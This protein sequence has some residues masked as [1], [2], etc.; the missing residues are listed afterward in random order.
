M[1]ADADWV[2]ANRPVIERAFEVF[3][4]TGEWPKTN[5]L[6]R[7]FAQ[8]G[9]TVDVD[10]VVRSRPSRTGELRMLHEPNLVL[11]I[12]HLRYLSAADD[13]LRVCIVATR[14]AVNAYRGAGEP[15]IASTDPQI[16]ESAGGSDRVLIRAGT[17]LQGEHPGPLSGGGYGPDHWEHYVNEHTIL[18]FEGVTTAD[19]FVSAQDAIAGSDPNVQALQRAAPTAGVDEPVDDLSVFVIMPFGPAWSRTVYE[20]IKRAAAAIDVTP[21]ATVRRSDDITHP[22]R[23]TDQIVDAIRESAVVVADITGLNANVMWELGYAH[24]LGK[25]AVILNQQISESPF[26]LVDHRQIGYSEHPTEDDEHR[27][28]ESLRSVLE[29]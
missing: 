27:L 4:D 15:K 11:N 22:G 21:K 19:E 25:D 8:R 20:M 6:R 5:E 1:S 12:R 16:A 13:V 3:M 28:V 26:D 29:H 10:A 14:C 18:D 24:A 9:A 2:N 7:S 17:V 23:I